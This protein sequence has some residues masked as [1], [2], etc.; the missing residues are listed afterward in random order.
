MVGPISGSKVSS[1]K[2]INKLGEKEQFIAQIL[3]CIL[4]GQGCHWRGQALGERMQQGPNLQAEKCSGPPSPCFVPG[5]NLSQ[6][7]KANGLHL[8]HV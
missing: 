3:I 1:A 7:L 6:K 8:Q 4:T 2:R 5:N